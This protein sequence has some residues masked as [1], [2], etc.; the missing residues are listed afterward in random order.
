MGKEI[1]KI[2]V[3]D[4]L[5]L[6]NARLSLR[7]IEEETGIPA[8]EAG[9]RLTALWDER[10]WR[11]ALQD[12][13][14]LIQD[15][16][17]ITAEI[18]D[19]MRSVDDEFYADMANAAI[20]AMNSIGQRWDARRKLIEIDINQITAA[21]GVIFGQAFEIA[22]WHIGDALMDKYEV[23]RAELRQL[24]MEGMKEARE[25]LKDYTV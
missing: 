1:A 2:S 22:L 13:L 23:P 8:A 16:E 11:S 5:L 14:V 24:A 19:K 7:E 10:D 21:Q 4:R 20:R 25:K 15:F 3:S 17:D 9:A 6:R 18:R 12:E